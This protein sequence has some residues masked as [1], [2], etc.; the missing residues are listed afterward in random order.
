VST[1]QGKLVE[2]FNRIGYFFRRLEIYT[3]VPP[4]PT[5]TDIIVEI[6]VKVI[7]ILGITTKEMQ[8]GRLSELVARF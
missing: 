3:R 7:T 4:T 5:M 6:M 8:R 2:L 1:S